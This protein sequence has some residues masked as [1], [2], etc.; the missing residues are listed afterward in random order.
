LIRST[1]DIK[2][3]KQILVADDSLFTI[4][5]ALWGEAAS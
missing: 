1:G 3:K 4:S 5:V 2:E